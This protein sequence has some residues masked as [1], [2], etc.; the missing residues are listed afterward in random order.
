MAQG[1]GE[2]TRG[3]DVLNE[4]PLVSGHAIPTMCVLRGL[5]VRRHPI[6]NARLA[7][8]K[9]LTWHE[10]QSSLPSRFGSKSLGSNLD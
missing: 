3:T 6:E 9:T 1:A 8:V 4:P 2:R 7:K 10:I 5:T